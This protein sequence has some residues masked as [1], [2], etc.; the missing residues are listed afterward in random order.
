MKVPCSPKVPASGS[1]LDATGE[2]LALVE[3]RWLLEFS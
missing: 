1:G 3:S 2:F